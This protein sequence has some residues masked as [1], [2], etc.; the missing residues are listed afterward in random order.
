M[1]DY[2]PSMRLLMRDWKEAR[3]MRDEIRRLTVSQ[4]LAELTSAALNCEG[5]EYE[6]RER[7]LRYRMKVSRPDGPVPWYPGYD[8]TPGAPPASKPFACTSFWKVSNS[9][10]SQTEGCESDTR[11]G[12]QG[13]GPAFSDGSRVNPKPVEYPPTSVAAGTSTAEGVR[14]ETATG[15]VSMGMG[16]G[17]LTLTPRGQPQ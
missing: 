9:E 16:Q 17:G 6:V 2:E 7:L 4:V 13:R 14:R 11:A 15:S 12:L 1:S 5:V 10:S 8:D 3:R